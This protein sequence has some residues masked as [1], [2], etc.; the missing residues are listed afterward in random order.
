MIR[1]VVTGVQNGKAVILSDGEPQNLHE[2]SGWPGHV[3]SVVWATAADES[4]P[5][6]LSRQPAPDLRVTPEPG[7]T[8]MLIVRFPP[9]SVFADPRFDGAAYA[10][11]A[12][13]FLPGLIDCFEP[14]NPGMHTT[15]SVD[16]DVVLDG[17]VWLELDD[18][19]QTHLRQGDIVIQG[20]ARHA[21]RNKSGEAATMLFVLVGARGKTV[22]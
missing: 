21:W 11:E 8:R 7:E 5:L 10:T 20:G 9:D 19:V 6:D 15:E 12:Q 3:T 1:R 18:G 2:Y 17:E 4:L 16:Y 22:D 13:Q 14:D